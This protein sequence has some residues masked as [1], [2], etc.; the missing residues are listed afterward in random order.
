MRSSN[1]NTLLLG[2]L[3]VL[4]VVIIALIVYYT[5]PR[6][7]KT[8]DQTSDTTELK[9]ENLTFERTLNPDP[10]VGDGVSGYTIEPYGIEYDTGETQYKELSKNVTF[11]MNWT[12]AP[13]FDN[14][15]KGFKIEHFVR[16]PTD[17]AD[18]IAS[19]YKQ[20]LIRTTSNKRNDEKISISDFGD[21]SAKIVSNGSYSVIGQNSFKLYAVV[22]KNAATEVDWNT[23]ATQDFVLLYNGV[24]EKVGEGASA[25]PPAPLKILKDQ[26][27]ATMTMTKPETL[28]YTPARPDNTS[29]RA[30]IDKT[31]YNVTNNTAN[32]NINGNG[33]YLTTVSDKG[34]KQY[35]FTYEDGQ[36][37]LDD[38]T[39]GVITTTNNRTKFTFEIIDKVGSTGYIRQVSTGN[40]ESKKKYLSSDKDGKLKLY[41]QTDGGLTQDIFNG[42]KWTFNERISKMISYNDKTN[43]FGTTV[44]ISG[45]DAFI[46][47]PE[48]K[49]GNKTKA[50]RVTYYKRSKVGVWELKHNITAPMPGA[51]NKFGCSI[52]ASGDFVVIGNDGKNSNKGGAY[53]IKRSADG[54]FNQN[55]SAANLN[56]T[57]VTN[58]DRAG[59]SVAIVGDTIVVGIP[60]RY[61]NRGAIRMYTRNTTSNNSWKLAFT[62]VEGMFL[63]GDDSSLSKFGAFVDISEDQ[64]QIIVGAPE[65]N[66]NNKNNTGA[67]HI[68]KN[69]IDFR[70]NPNQDGITKTTLEDAN[71]ANAKFGTHVS[72]SGKNGM[73]NAVVGSGLSTV[74]VYKY[75]SSSS[76]WL[77]ARVSGLSTGDA[78]DNMSNTITT[79]IIPD[80]VSISGDTIVIGHSTKDENTGE[81]TVVKKNGSDGSGPFWNKTQSISA[82]IKEKGSK[83]GKSVHTDGD[84]IIIGEPLRKKTENGTD[85]NGSFYITAI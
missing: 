12:N 13:G 29:S 35:N 79:G 80:S 60:G 37:L 66:K 82:S 50:G 1:D 63:L 4:I 9:V 84:Y 71:V 16:K 67:A 65:Q 61:N 23:P 20:T 74:F 47:D 10:S 39:K 21:C 19:A 30:I 64:Q 52:S 56:M 73:Y 24:G 15:V 7:T 44:C 2:G 68:F 26:L 22:K 59:E 85:T 28:K 57:E 45:D 51:Y 46:G 34:G 6:E 8:P 54:T 11:T 38:L 17:T 53:V 75:A 27:S 40:D 25:A 33:I 31:T 69:T 36:Y 18:P 72:I 83:F 5:R 49:H 43:M 48:Y 78:A 76:G 42:F 14:V 55:S 58:N 81:V 77:K 32:L 62:N 3:F 70:E 41:T